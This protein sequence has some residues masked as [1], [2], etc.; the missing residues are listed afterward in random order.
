[1]PGGYALRQF[2]AA[3][4]QFVVDAEQVGGGGEDVA[5]VNDAVGLEAGG[6][7]ADALSAA[8]SEAV[9][10]GV[11]FGG[12]QQEG[13]GEGGKEGEGENGVKRFFH[14]GMA[15]GKGRQYIAISD[16]LFALRRRR[17]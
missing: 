15:R 11:G 13:G 8:D 4:V 1:M 7:R 2:V 10:F 9:W 16:G 6:G 12:E 3:R 14:K 5:V 17:G